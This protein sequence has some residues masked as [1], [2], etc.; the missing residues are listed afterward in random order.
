MHR[1]LPQ[2]RAFTAKAACCSACLMLIVFPAIAFAGT[3][4]GGSGTQ[5]KPYRISAVP[6]WQEL[7]ATPADWDSHFVLTADIDLN[8][9]PMAPIGNDANNFT[10][11]FDG[12]D[13]II[14]NA[15]VNMPGSNYV[16]LFGY[17]G[18]DGQ[19][20]NLAVEDISVF[21]RDYV[22]GLVGRNYSTIVNC[23]SSGMV[24]GSRYYV[25]GLVGRNARGTISDCHS[26]A[27]VSGGEAL[28]GLVGYAYGDTIINCSASGSVSGAGSVGGLVGSNER[29]TISNCHSTGS[30]SGTGS[31][32]GGLV[33]F[34][35]SAISDCYSTGS[36]GGDRYVGGLVGANGDCMSGAHIP[37][38]IHNSY[39]TGSVTGTGHFVGGLVGHNGCGTISGSYATGSASGDGY[40]GGIVGSN[41]RGGAISNCY[42]SGTA[43][44]TGDYLGGLVGDNYSGAVS[45][46]Y[47]TGSVDGTGSYLGGLVGRNLGTIDSSFWDVNTAGWTTSAGGTPKTTAE[48]KTQSTFTD[49]A[50]DFIEVWDIGENQTYPF[51]R[52]YAAGDINHDG[53]VDFRDVTH[54]AGDWLSGL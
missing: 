16:G 34:S 36:V 20:K 19:I 39:S 3:Y 8:D 32:I 50:W 29:S 15:D 35:G 53:V 23:Y 14:R 49:A 26:T 44:G 51:L 40:V 31:Y 41:R 38:S 30:V 42:S 48:M 17:L 9:V 27:S 11:V 18:W 5:A 25:G 43:A 37:G 52:R 6:D 10:G 7:M 28:G 24:S 54:L 1:G 13:H 12:N 4:S 2:A 33:G 45:D 46:C 47:S 21:G 22:G